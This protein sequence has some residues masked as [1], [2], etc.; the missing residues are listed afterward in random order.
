[1]KPKI[2]ETKIKLP[3]FLGDRYQVVTLPH[4]MSTLIEVSGAQTEQVSSQAVEELGLNWII[5]QYD[6]QIN[7]MPKVYEEIRVK[8]YAKEFNRIF[9]YREFEV[10]DENG[11]LIVY[12]MTV[13]AL[14]DNERKLSRIPE[15]V[16]KDYG[17]TESR[18]IK[19]IPKP[20]PPENLETAKMQQYP[21]RYFD[22][23]GN[24]HANNATYF[25]WL[26][27]ALG[28]EFLA[29][30]EPMTGNITFEKEVHI[31]E[32]VDSYVDFTVDEDNQ[33]ISR[34][35]IK[36]GDTTKC[37][38]TFKWRDKDVTY[39]TKETPGEI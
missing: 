18:R 23:D 20:T 3:H 6:V 11:E 9:S 24:F 8:T 5:I 1:M 7:R 36:V 28:D 35:Q 26:L 32:V 15:F 10:Y 39:K 12:V 2:Y 34:H 37:V 29:T 38:A 14:M 25:E 4:L 13:F 19:R 33:I 30:H 17:S 31:D 21:V 16:G 22:I 27:D